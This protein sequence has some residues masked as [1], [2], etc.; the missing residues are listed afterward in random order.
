MDNKMNNMIKEFLENTDAENEEELNEA[1]GKFIEQYNAGEIEYENTP[2][3]EA[4]ELLEEAENAKTIKDAKR[5]AKK[6]FETS[7]ACFDAKL[8]L[9][10]I[11]EN[12]LKS[13]KIINEGLEFEKKRLEQE[14]YFDKENIGSFYGIFETRPYIRGLYTKACNLSNEGKYKKAIEVCKEILRLNENDNTGARYLLMALYAVIED[15]KAMLDLYK[16]YN[17]EINLEMLFPLFALYYKKEDDSK[18]K[19][20][21]DMINK[22]NKHFIKFFKETI[23]LEEDSMS[24]Y[25]SRGNASEVLM[26]MREYFFLVCTLS[27]INDY[28][29]ENSKNNN[30]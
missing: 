15:E 17:E 26:Y 19:K 9:A 1:L 25:Y 5:L 3:D 20:Y 4:Y 8:F 30:N 10:D 12:S 7:N 16:K 18:A 6:A 21:L 14:G 13:N 27:N 24:G 23:K 22:A 28:I 11:E 29:L 2:L